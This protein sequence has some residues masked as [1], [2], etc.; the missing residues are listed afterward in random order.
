MIKHLTVKS[1]NHLGEIIDVRRIR[2]ICFIPLMAPLH[3]S[4]GISLLYFYLPRELKPC[5]Q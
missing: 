1:I 4:K 2:K 3:Y 5:L